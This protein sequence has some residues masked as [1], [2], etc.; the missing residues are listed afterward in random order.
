MS[1]HSD[2]DLGP[3]LAAARGDAAAEKTVLF[4]LSKRP[5]LTLLNQPPGDGDAAPYRNLV[6]WERNSD[7]TAIVPVFTTKAWVTIPIPPPAQLVSVPM[8]ILITTCGPRRYVINLLSKGVGFEIDQ[9]R[10]GVL[11]ACIAEQGY[12]WD[13]P[14]RESP[15]VFQFPDDAL[16][17]VGCALAQWFTDHGRVD[18]AYMYEVT[19]MRSSLRPGKLVVLGLNEPLDLELA[20]TLTAV[21]VQAG[22]PRDEFVVRFIPEEP[23]HRAG[24]A[25]IQLQ[26]FWKRPQQ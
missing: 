15:W 7:G 2:E 10:W 5:V 9:T 4:E 23:S 16:Y 11:Q 13:A 25:G 18:E 22:A 26:P 1:I 20:K 17:P 19:R 8:R 12:E 14:S 6:Q 3:A 21:A 24:I